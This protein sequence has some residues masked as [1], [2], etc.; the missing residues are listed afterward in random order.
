MTGSNDAVTRTAAKKRIK[1]IALRY[2]SAFFRSFGSAELYRDV[3]QQ[4]R[5]VGLGYLLFALAFLWVPTAIT[6]HFAFTH[7]IDSESAKVVDQIPVIS[8]RNGQVETDVVTPYFIRTPENMAS[9]RRS[10]VPYMAVIDLTGRYRSLED[11]NALAL[12]TRNSLVLRNSSNETR[13]Y[14]LSAVQSFQMDKVRVRG[15]LARGRNF[16]AP[17]LYVFAVVGSLLYRIAQ[18]VLY[19][20]IG[21]LFARLTRTDLRFPTLMRL[22]AVA[23]TPAL[24]ADTLVSLVQIHV[25]M[26]PLVCFLLAT[27]YLFFG[28]KASTAG[29]SGLS[30]ESGIC[31]G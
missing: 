16:V 2:L 29:T 26:W 1:E 9:Q 10:A 6:V 28:V 18:A 20:V 19:G 30:I 22:A 5:G 21:L 11:V 3:A 23:V 17:C 27:G 8:I 12:L 4:W 13:T 31:A 25:P 14:A 24:V 7:W 15:W